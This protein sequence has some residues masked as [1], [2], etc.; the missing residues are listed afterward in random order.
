MTDKKT[1]VLHR[2]QFLQGAACVVGAA[3]LGL[4]VRPALSGTPKWLQGNEPETPL[5]IGYW[6]GTRFISAHH[7][8]SGDSAL[9]QTGA[10]VRIH[11]ISNGQKPLAVNAHYRVQV[12]DQDQTVPF[13]A[14]TASEHG[15]AGISF[16]M[17]VDREQGLLLS[18]LHGRETFCKLS[19]D[20]ANGAPK[21]RTGTYILAP[22]SVNL[23]ACQLEQAGK[24]AARLTRRSL[25][26]FVPVAFDYVA[27]TI[28][29][30]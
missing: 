16:R 21:L 28:T 17:P 9:C 13:H 6:D 24:D 20:S 14:W 22:G 2:R 3:T 11:G 8:T 10:L 30:A 12:G 23:S 4:A 7:L 18:V 27:V 29:Q 1:T 5:S 15:S 26:G 19:V 25:R